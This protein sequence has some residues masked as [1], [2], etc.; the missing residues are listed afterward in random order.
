VRKERIVNTALVVQRIGDT[1]VIDRDIYHKQLVDALL[2]A[3]IPMTRSF[4]P[5]RASLCQT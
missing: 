4:S 1:I 5:T 3:G 2:Q